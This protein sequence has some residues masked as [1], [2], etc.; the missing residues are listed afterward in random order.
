MSKKSKQKI[1]VKIEAVNIY[2][3]I[4]DTDQLSVIRG[5]S[6]LLKEAAL[7]I[8]E[9]SDLYTHYVSQGW[10]IKTHRKGA[11]VAVYSFIKKAG[12]IKDS[13]LEDQLAEAINRHDQ[14]KHFNFVV[15]AVTAKSLKDADQILTAKGRFQ[16]QQ[17]LTIPANNHPNTDNEPY[18]SEVSG[19]RP[20]W[21]T[22]E[23]GRPGYTTSES[24]RFEYGRSKRSD[25][26][27]QEI[28]S[29]R[30]ANN[31]NLEELTIDFTSDLQSLAEYDKAGNLNNKIA[32]I[33]TDANALGSMVTSALSSIKKDEYDSAI[34]SIDRHIE[35]SRQEFLH[36]LVRHFEA[37]SDNPAYCRRSSK[38]PQA[39]L[40][41][42][43]W[44][45]DEMLLVVPAWLGLEI[46]NL[47][48]EFSSKWTLKTNQV[49]SE[50]KIKHAGGLVF[51]RAKTP[52]YKMR[53][54]AQQLA[55]R[56][57]ETDG[58]RDDD[59]FDYIV[60][61][62][63]DYPTES[64]LSNFFDNLYGE[65]LC[66]NRGWL[67]PYGK[68]FGTIQ[69]IIRDLLND[70]PKTQLYKFVNE[71]LSKENQDHAT[72]LS[73]FKERLPPDLVDKVEGALA[74]VIHTAKSDEQGLWQWIHLIEL[75]DYLAPPE[76]IFTPINQRVKEEA[77]D[78]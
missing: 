33:Y 19:I 7:I 52:I 46:M 23:K 60:L 72:T 42:L 34:K 12:G 48:Y 56:I 76:E 32:V 61:E 9:D 16:Q 18:S 68:S 26:Y 29:H 53:Y 45:G 59:Y 5:G 49:I 21:K 67:R 51:C 40:E 74:P 35:N 77:I 57:K 43:L 73:C 37:N 30:E 8:T 54:L 64:S 11:S 6:L 24:I 15:S 41:T 44:G 2:A 47:F 69:K 3:N 31:L 62:S 50:K 58:G 25:M 14:Y 55:D 22:P 1:Y 20:V 75:Y 28:K 63:I 13:E 17:Q 36:E 4:G 27:L 10:K 71:L 65:Q 38:K 66:L 39:R 78:E 70:F